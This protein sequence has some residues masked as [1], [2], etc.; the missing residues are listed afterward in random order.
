MPIL[1]SIPHFK[2]KL[3][4]PYPILGHNDHG[5][6]NNYATQYANDW[7]QMP[8]VLHMHPECHLDKDLD[9]SHHDKDDVQESRIDLTSRYSCESNEG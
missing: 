2:N 6:D 8:A 7:K 4:P 9:N 1:S 5:D 3:L